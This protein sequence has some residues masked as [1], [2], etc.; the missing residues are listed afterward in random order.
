M[1]VARKGSSLYVHRTIRSIIN[2]GGNVDLQVINNSL[3]FQESIDLEIKMISSYGMD[4]LTNLTAGG[5]GCTWQKTASPQELL[6]WKTSVSNGRKDKK[7]VFFSKEGSKE[8]F[9]FDSLTSAAKYFSI[10]ISAIQNALK[11]GHK[12]KK[13]RVSLVP[14]FVDKPG[15]FDELFS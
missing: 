6:L 4:N 14:I 8:H 13:H 3:S 2:N 7:K 12:V 10:D 1:A 5:E 9:E 15:E 11:R